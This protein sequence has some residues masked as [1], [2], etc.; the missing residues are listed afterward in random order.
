ME[1]WIYARNFHRSLYTNV[2]VE[3]SY[4]RSKLGF[5]ICL[6]EDLTLS[7]PMLNASRNVS[8]LNI[9]FYDSNSPIVR[10]FL[11]GAIIDIAA[12][13]VEHR[14]KLRICYLW[15]HLSHL[16]SLDVDPQ[17][18]WEYDSLVDFIYRDK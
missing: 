3:G 12:S 9:K 16:N 10:I 6:F 13:R 14:Y 18:K 8:F 11:D 2:V 5:Y 4:C 17:L 7:Y 15:R 1:F